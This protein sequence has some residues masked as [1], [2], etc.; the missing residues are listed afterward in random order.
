[1]DSIKK[2]ADKI[3]GTNQP[4]AQSGSE[5]VSG[6]TGAGSAGQP[7][8]QGNGKRVSHQHAK[9]FRGSATEGGIATGGGVLGGKSHATG[10][11]VVPQ[12]VQEAVPETLERALPDTIHDT[13]GA[14]SS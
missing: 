11:S 5:P 2:T 6:S 9:S 12:G 13:S 4:A 10:D 1:M 14:T 7:Y 3:L 8:D